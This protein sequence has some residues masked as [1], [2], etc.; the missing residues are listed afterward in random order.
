[1]ADVKGFSHFEI[2]SSSDGSTFNRIA[3]VPYASNQHKYTYTDKAVASGKSFYRLKL[4]DLDGTYEYSPV[5][6]VYTDCGNTRIRVYPT[7]VT[8]TLQVELPK[9]YEHAGFRIVNAAGI[10]V[11]PLLQGTGLMRTIH[12]QDLPAAAYLLQIVD[13]KEI[14]SFRF[15]KQ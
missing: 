4:T 7:V 10:S 11:T 9:G 1:V 8:N 5:V 6:S 14:Q 12:L 13:G 15:I 2:E 3:D